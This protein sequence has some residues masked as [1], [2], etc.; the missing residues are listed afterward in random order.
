MQV[1]FDHLFMQ[2]ISV[3]TLEIQSSRRQGLDPINHATF[4]CNSQA[5]TWISYAICR[6]SF[7]VYYYFR[8]LFVLLIL[9][10]LLAST[11]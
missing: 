11:F 4:L 9:V 7:F 1:Y 2:C 5:R 3:L 10:E 6:V 8:W